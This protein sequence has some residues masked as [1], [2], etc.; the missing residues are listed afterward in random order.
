MEKIVLFE[1]SK[2]DFNA[3]LMNECVDEYTPFMELIRQYNEKVRANDVYASEDI[4]S[5]NKNIIE[6]VVIYSDDFASVTDHVISNFPN[7]VLLGH[8]IENVY[9]QNAP[10][11]VRY[12]LEVGFEDIID[13]K[14]SDYYEADSEDIL[15]LFSQ[16]ENGNIVGQNE[17]KKQS[18]VGLYK[19]TV[20]KEDR[21]LVLLY[22]GPS[23]VGKTELA[24][25]ISKFYEG[26]LTRIQFSM[27]QT[28]EAYKYIFGDAHGKPSLARDLLNRETNI[29]LIDEFDKVSSTLYNVFYQMFDEGEFED[30]NYKVD[31]SNC[32]FILTSNF[33][34][35]KHIA[36]VLGFPIY[37][38][39]DSKIKFSQLTNEE[40]ELVIER[41]F[42]RIYS[43][44]SEEDRLLIDK[45]ELKGKYKESVDIFRNIRLL[46]KYIEN[47]I[48]SILFDNKIILSL[49]N[50]GV[51][52]EIANK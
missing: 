3:L 39:I 22:Y 1:G 27:M 33:N 45:L 31:V 52:N 12:A 38:R 5:V 51:T 40:L 20:L 28:D 41:I 2:K 9:I 19:S 43:R 24:K 18:C 4:G 48:F 37:S 47:D 26:G 50:G 7:I 25:S 14:K 15:R 30:I 8:N 16:L 36:E 44:I 23:G 49:T 32:V 46:D 17:A 13:R 42:D 29:V 11:R 21:P 34:S 35:E 6:N 10:K